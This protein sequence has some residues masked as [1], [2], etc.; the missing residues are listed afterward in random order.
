V[1][2][3]QPF[4]NT[5][6]IYQETFPA[7]PFDM[8]Y[9]IIKNVKDDL[10]PG[11][12]DQC[13]VTPGLVNTGTDTFDAQLL[14]NSPA[15]DA[16]LA[17]AA[18]PDIGAFEYGS[19]PTPLSVKI[20]LPLILRAGEAPIRTSTPT[21]TPTPTATS[22]TGADNPN[23][24]TDPVKLIFVHHSTGG[25]WLADPAGNEL[26]GDLGRALMNNN[27]FVSATN[28]GWTVAGDVI[29]DRTDIGNWW[30]W[31]RGPNSANILAAL[32]AENGRNFG[33]YG[34]WPRLASDPGGENQIVVFKSC[35]PDSALQG[36]PG[37]APPPIASNPLRGQEAY[38]EYHTVANAKGIY[39]D[40]LEYFGTRQDKLFVV[41][42]A[43]PLHDGAWASNAC[44]FNDWLVNDWLSGYPYENVAVFD[45]Y[46]VLTS[47][48]GDP[49]TNDLGWH[50]GNHHRWWNG[51]V[52]HQQTVASDTAAYPSGDD[53]PN[54]AGNTKAKG[55]F[56]QLFNASVT[57]SFDLT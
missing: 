10:C 36:D 8:D 7:D 30:E 57:L 14:S 3:W 20:Y 52:Q 41:I 4:E 47:N 25:N 55:E 48:G 28:Y 6:L 44:A 39:M 46:N 29:D 32:Y 31:F 40:L 21:A 26:G 56:V 53:H 45:F 54:R 9:S 51:A 1:D 13:G 34:A 18:P 33:D 50:S 11:T 35:F 22:I 19:G 12:H 24:P 37:A 49:D 15:I 42:T 5:C 2:F 27:Y 16:A 38:S 17:S 23:P 43:P